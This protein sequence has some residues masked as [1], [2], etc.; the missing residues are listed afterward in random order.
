MGYFSS[1]TLGGVGI[2]A[3]KS[4]IQNNNKITI[5]YILWI[6]ETGLFLHVNILW[7][8]QEKYFHI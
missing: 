7:V 8:L 1:L 4:V 6:L 3:H 2:C 5:W